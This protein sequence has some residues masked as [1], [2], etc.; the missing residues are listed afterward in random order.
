LFMDTIYSPFT[1]NV[2]RQIKSVGESALIREIRAW[3]GP[4]CPDGAE[5]IGDDCAV[6]PL[7]NTSGFG[8]TT[9]DGVGYGSHFDDKVPP[10]GVGRKLMGRNVSDIAS[11]G[12]RPVRAVLSLWLAPDTSVDWLRSMYEGVA[13]MAREYS[14]AVVGG[15]VARANAGVCIVDLCLQGIAERPLLRQQCKVGDGVWVTGE[16]GGSF[17]GKHYQFTPRVAEGLWLANQPGVG[18]MI[19]ISDGIAKDLRALVGDH[20][21][22]MSDVPI[23]D[24]AHKLSLTSGKSPEYHAWHDG[25]DFELAF[26]TDAQMDCSA[27]L[28]NWN[29]VFE[30]KLT[31]LGKINQAGG[32]QVI[33]H[34]SRFVELE[35]GYEHF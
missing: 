14:I 23:S 21:I 33:G 27:F 12:G 30:T 4:V 11:M 15:D 25:E 32:F 5:G 26:T 29:A 13:S 9:V 31:Y 6:F 1:S 28:E 16:L 22:L 7:A 2:D 20:E 34:D 3:L 8:L 35:S 18:S 19:D 17:L 10:E 24:A